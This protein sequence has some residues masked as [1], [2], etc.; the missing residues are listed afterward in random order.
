MFDFSKPFFQ[1]VSANFYLKNSN[2]AFD[3]S[4]ITGKKIGEFNY[5]PSM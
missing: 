3:A 5:I 2:V 4:D 1:A